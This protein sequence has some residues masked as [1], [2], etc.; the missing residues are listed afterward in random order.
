AD[1]SQVQDLA[2]V[3]EGRVAGDDREETEAQK[4]R[5]DVLRDAVREVFL[6]YLAAQVDEG[7]HRDGGLLER[8]LCRRWRD[9]SLP[10]RNFGSRPRP[11]G[12][13]LNL[14]IEILDLR[15]RR[16]IQLA[17][18]RIAAVV[19]LAYRLLELALRGIGVHQSA[20]GGF[21]QGIESHEA[22]A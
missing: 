6:L 5:D 13:F 16:H 8:R 12:A 11:I 14:P 21:A 17:S 2:L 10:R 15:R 18:Q 22:L 1:L 3:G 9:R 20:V 19:V 4:L 7:K